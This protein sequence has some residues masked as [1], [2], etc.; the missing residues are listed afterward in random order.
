MVSLF[1]HSFPKPQPLTVIRDKT[2]LAFNSI[3]IFTLATIVKS[4]L[5][6]M[7]SYNVFDP[8]SEE[9]IH[10]MLLEEDGFFVK[11][12][13]TT[14]HHAKDIKRYHIQNNFINEM[15]L[16]GKPYSTLLSDL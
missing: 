15:K 11:Q 8:V 6:L 9:M 2:L 3:F 5:Y 7:S 13:W 10:I 1:T 14:Q 16:N 12:I 4:F